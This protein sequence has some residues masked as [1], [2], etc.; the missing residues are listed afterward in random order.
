MTTFIETIK[1]EDSDI[2]LF[3]FHQQRITDTAFAHSFES[4]VLPKQALID[5][6]KITSKRVK[7]RIEYTDK[8]IISVEYAPYELRKLT[9]LKLVYDDYIDYCFK[10]SD[11][12]QLN[13]LREHCAEF[14][15]IIII[16]DGFVTD[17]SYANLVFAK[18]GR[19]YTP[20]SYLLNGVRRQSLLSANIIE[21]CEISVADISKF[22]TIMLINGMINIGEVVIVNY[23]SETFKLYK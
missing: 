19:L 6:C 2:E 7:C 5:G 22:D 15:D 11:R 13:T 12:S 18:A 9:T 21:E 23:R 3:E 14:E 1:I 20:K 17:C 4:F 16:K 8:G 10:R